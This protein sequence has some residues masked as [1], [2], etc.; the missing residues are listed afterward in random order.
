MGTPVGTLV[1][2]APVTIEPGATV[3]QAAA[4]MSDSRISS[5]LV[6]QDGLLQGIV[7]DR[8]L[9]TR[10]V[11]AGLDTARPV[12]EI[13]TASP[14][15]VDALMTAFDAF[16]LMTRRNL[17]HLPVMD[18]QR[19]V[20]MLTPSDISWHQS[21]SAVF[22]AQ[23][24]FRQDRVEDMQTVCAR[25]PTLQR[26]LSQ[27]DA[28][29][30]AMGRVLTAIVDTLT[31]RLLTLA[32]VRL[33]PPPVP[34][35]WVAAGSQARHELTA[36]SDQD[37]C[38]VLSDDYDA[39]R[40]HDYF[41]ALARSVCAGLN[42]CGYVY[43]PGEMMAITDTWRQPAAT[44]RSRFE[45]WIDQ[46]SPQALMQTCVFF[47][48]RAVHGSAELLDAV[49]ADVLHKTRDSSI[50]LA[51][52][53][54]NAVARRPPLTL[55]GR[56]ATSRTGPN[57]GTLDLKLSGIAPVV[58]LARIYALASGEAAVNTRQRLQ[59]AAQT[60]Q[61]SSQGAE[62]LRDTLEFLSAMR[63]RHQVRQSEAGQVPDN[64]VSPSELSNF[65]RTQLK[66]AFKAVADQQAA[67]AQRY[68]LARF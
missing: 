53:A 15:T 25:V 36:R 46:P 8:D 47:D 23:D 30:D 55:F 12:A 14:V 48:L 31:V 43:C 24:I 1:R 7:T 66:D 49:R 50:F 19:I 58:D 32:E 10:V 57:R 27:A 6:T 18:G 44:W 4:L 40:H 51:H 60:H 39:S 56:L 59:A 21:T 65:E 16:M 29:A 38:M 22:L 52:L 34:Y 26:N 3:R 63:I 64:R 61:I 33:G 9:R 20:G 54:R 45:A 11:A 28:T 41:E 62:D 68:Q 67:L 13:A 2:R 17:H 42:A 37:N 35:V 5:L